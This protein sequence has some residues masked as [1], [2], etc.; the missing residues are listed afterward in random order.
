MPVVGPTVFAQA[1]QVAPADAHPVRGKIVGGFRQD[2]LH[3]DRPAERVLGEA[4]AVAFGWVG[5]AGAAQGH[6]PV[7]RYPVGEF[8]RVRLV[9]EPG[10]QAAQDPAVRHPVDHADLLG[11]LQDGLVP[12]VRDRAVRVRAGHGRPEHVVEP[13]AARIRI[14]I[15]CGCGVRGS[16]VIA[17]RGRRRVIRAGDALRQ[18]LRPVASIVPVHDHAG[19]YA[20]EAWTGSMMPVSTAWA[21]PQGQGPAERVCG[22]LRRD[23]RR[24]LRRRLHLPDRAYGHHRERGIKPSG[25]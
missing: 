20:R 18:A 11:R 8:G 12:V 1:V 9:R 4:G 5:G 3:A 23:G 17:A 19:T 10:F 6:E 13:Q 22:R 25:A 2:R 14:R 7:G 15:R 24:T 16:H 21:E